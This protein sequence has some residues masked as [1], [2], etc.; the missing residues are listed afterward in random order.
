MHNVISKLV[1]LFLEVQTSPFLPELVRLYLELHIRHDFKY[2]VL[3]K[4]VW[5]YLKVH[6]PHFQIHVF[7]TFKTSMPLHGSTSATIP[8]ICIFTYYY[9]CNLLLIHAYFD[10][11]LKKSKTTKINPRK[12]REVLKL[13]ASAS[14]PWRSSVFYNWYIK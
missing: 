8:N 1:C 12:K 7:Y 6:V 13:V 4:L 14:W 3:W 11:F 5:M 2:N 10:F 9:F